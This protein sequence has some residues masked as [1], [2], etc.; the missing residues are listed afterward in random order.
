MSIPKLT[1]DL[2]IIQKLSDLPN[3]TE[4]LTAEQL[5]AKFDEAGLEIQRWIN[6]T[7]VPAITAGNIPFPKSAEVDAETVEAAILAVWQQITDAASGAIIDG[8]VTKAKLA[9]TL[10][11]RVYGGRSW[12]SL[13]EPDSADN[14]DNDFPVG[15][16][17]LRPAFTVNNMD[18]DNW[19]L[20]GCTLDK[21]SGT[22]VMTGTRTVRTA[23]ME[24]TISGGAIEG[25]RIYVLFDTGNVDSEMTSF[26]VSVN[27]GS[28][29]DAT[30]SG[31]FVGE[32]TGTTVSIKFKAEWP[33]TSLAGGRAEIK[34]LAIVNVD[35]ILRNTGN[36]K[37]RKNWAAFLKGLRTISK[38]KIPS[39]LY[40]QKSSGEWWDIGF[41]VVPIRRGGTGLTEIGDGELLYGKDGGFAR[42]EKPE[43]LS[44][45]QFQN[46]NPFWAAMSVMAEHGYARIATGSYVGT[47]AARTIVLP[48]TPKLL[49]ISTDAPSGREGDGLFQQGVTRYQTMSGQRNDGSMTEVLYEAGLT[50]TENTL[51]TKLGTGADDVE[52]PA[53][54][55]W[56]KSGKTYPWVAIY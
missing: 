1:N 22:H 15:Q 26:S 20:I 4:G 16:I 24:Q 30:S 42:L 19:T 31:V 14:P 56:N 37:E 23:T 3:S 55:G 21:V 32:A 13:D 17:W 39:A 43:E 35:E 10:L 41:E 28:E 47:G 18:N 50:L 46:G 44:F 48:I 12:V 25:D 11:E 34:N 51:K 5:K 38:T 29:Q 45:L 53:H 9:A 54:K 7:L 27:D 8:T 52:N 2:A 49:I 36:A 40:I 33:S 6:E